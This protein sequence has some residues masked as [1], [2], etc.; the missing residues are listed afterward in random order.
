MAVVM[1]EAAVSMVEVRGFTAAGSAEASMAVSAF[2]VEDSEVSMEVVFIMAT[3]ASQSG[4]VVAG[5]GV[6]GAGVAG[7]GVAGAGVAGA[8]V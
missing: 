2:T 1:A 3:A 4:S 5:A 8:G 7:A 6:A